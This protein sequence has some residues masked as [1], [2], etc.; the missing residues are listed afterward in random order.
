MFDNLRR[1]FKKVEIK[2]V[3]LIF[4]MDMDENGQ[5]I[6]RIIRQNS[7]QI[8]SL[9]SMN[10]LLAY[11]F[12]EESIENDHQI[13][14]ILSEKD[15]QTILSLKSLNPVFKSDGS[16]VFDIEPPVL[17][18]LRQKRV[19]ET[20][21]AR[22]VRVM[23]SPIKP[24]AKVSYDQDAGVK[25][26]TGYQLPGEQELVPA[27]D[28]KLTKDGKYTRLGNTFVPIEKVSPQAE[29][30][31][32]QGT[33]SYPIKNIPEFFLRDLVLLK[34]EFN[35]V[36]TDLAG[37]IQIVTDSLT[38]VVNVSKDHQGW[39]DFEIH[40][41]SAGFH[42]PRELV[43]QAKD[44]GENFIQ[45]DPV[46]WVE[47]DE[48]TIEK[49]EKK[50][51]ELEASLTKDGY[52]LPASEFASLEEFIETI[53]GKSI[54]DAA[55]QEFINQ[56]TGFQA[57]QNFSLSDDFEKHLVQFGLKLRPYQRAGIH[58]LNWLRKNHLHGVLADDM[59]LGKTLQSLAV[60]RL[61]YDETKSKNHSL[62][63][64]PKSVLV[65]W[66]REIQ[67]VFT[68][69]RTYVYH[70]SGRRRDFFNSSN[71]YIFITTYET[72][73]R[74]SEFLATIPFNY[75]ILDEATRIKN[76]DARRSQAIKALNA[77]HRLALS[78][79]P[80][81]N[82]PSELW[83]LFDFLMKGHLGKHGTFINVF[84]N[85][86]M[87]GQTTAAQRLGRRIKP[88]LLRR[89][90]EAVADDL[91]PK[92]VS[93][94][95]VSLTGEQRELYGAMQDQIRNLRN[96]IL[97]GEQLN[98]TA[99]ILP[100][101]TKLKQICDHPALVTG[102]M[103]P[104][105][106]RSEKF[107]TIIDKVDEIIESGDQ[108]IIFSHFLNMLSLFEN[109]IKEKNYPYIRIDGSTNQRQALVDKFNNGSAKV[110]LLS[111][112]AAGYGINLTGANHVIHADRWWNP[113]VEDQATDRVHRIG[114]S[115]TVFVW[116]F[117]TTGTLEEK[118]DRLLTRKR[119][120][121]GQIVG[122]ASA[123]EHKWSRE[124]LLELLKPLD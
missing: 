123:G 97:R 77:E 68:F 18:Y 44:K 79:T 8:Q 71:P 76:P 75:L 32:Q 59:G 114:Q 120:I 11:D 27:G 38:P 54:L 124:D 93:T 9:E 35:A 21:N 70:G 81:E 17:N 61:E 34:K 1:L 121:A 73:T 15:R 80:V 66:E 69:M 20:E 110:A 67:R 58:W 86:I 7:G 89:K 31:L 108:V 112:M 55:Y 16:L 65:H 84:E 88:F 78:G 41:N 64:A 6:V 87:A 102:E 103:E 109:V 91:P 25:V 13:I 74:D 117:L 63:I 82:K 85:S 53:G 96:S 106:G 48:N 111:I 51:K 99:S 115:K 72:I 36:L 28:I 46:T 105:S 43:L 26:E 113:A 92:I 45:L 3:E 83:S 60:L 19:F 116:H 101:L 47:L 118:I 42:L 122:A 49:T 39:L 23:E 12:R 90:K 37:K 24:V 107:D 2:P 40:Y 33:V 52:R 98:Y 29:G 56:L 95:W 62:V 100:V 50:L 119:E 104:I 5:H 10:S 22:V 30:I 94:E 4:S 14:H 57:D